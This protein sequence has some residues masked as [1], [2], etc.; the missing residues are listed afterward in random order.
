MKIKNIIPFIAIITLFSLGVWQL[1]RLHEKNEFISKLM[2]GYNSPPISVSELDLKNAS[3]AKVK[4]NGRFLDGKDIYLYGKR[5]LNTQKISKNP[6]DGYNLISP[7]K[8]DDGKIILV[9]RGWFASSNKE[10]MKDIINIDN[11]EIVGFVMNFEK[12]SLVPPKNDYQKNIIFRLI[13]DELENYIGMGE[14]FPFYISATSTN[15]KQNA[16]LEE[17]V[18]G[19]PISRIPNNHLE[20]VLTWF[21]LALVAAVIVFLKMREAR[22]KG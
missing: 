6:I 19:N 18:P 2:L 5:L 15:N 9:N 13:H 16:L 14:I 11:E 22:G 17:A 12:K 10:Q 20:Y 1:L 4:I 3:Y 21:S 8:T 7:M